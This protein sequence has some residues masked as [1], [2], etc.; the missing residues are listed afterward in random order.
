MASKEVRYTEEF[1]LP[2][3]NDSFVKTGYT[4]SGWIY[5]VNSYAT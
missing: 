3:N 4:F 5:E 1:A 2:D